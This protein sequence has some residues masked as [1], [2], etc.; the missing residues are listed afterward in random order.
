[1]NITK[2]EICLLY[3]H[4]FSRIA[5]EGGW[6]VAGQIASVVGSFVLLRVLTEYIDPAQYGQLALGLTVAGLINQ[7]VMGGVIAGISRYYPIACEKSDLYGYFQASVQ[8]MAYATLAVATLG[9]ILLAGLYWFDHV[10]WI[11]LAS[12]ALIF[13]V[14][15]AYNAAL[16][17]IQNAARQRAIVAFHSSLDSWLKI[18]LAVAAIRW[19]GSSSTAVVIGY[20]VSA[21]LV[22][23][24]QFLFLNKLVH[25]E[26]QMKNTADNW[27]KQMW[28]YSL[29]ISTWGIFTWAQ[30]ASD[31]WALQRCASTD[32]VGQYAVVFQLGYTP[33]MLATGLA[34]TLLGPVLFQKSG[35]ATNQQRIANVQSLSWRLVYLC[36]G[37]TLLAFLF[38][39]GTH[40]WIFSLLVAPVYRSVSYLLPWMLL[41]GGLFSAGQLLGLKLLCD[42]KPHAM[43]W[44]KIFTAIL[45]VALN[46]LG[47]NIAGLPGVVIAAI[48]FSSIYFLWMCIL[49]FGSIYN[50]R[51][52]K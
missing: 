8:I 39:M 44:P 14:F 42:L 3:I 40:R 36:L 23:S 13:S 33:I 28:L 9:T 38:A 34:T 50:P 6:I 52:I 49:N 21:L 45:G 47:A 35:D 19:I 24:S 15:S 48:L 25:S 11:G 29:P 26:V 1:M 46:I 32:L 27:R 17:S 10:Q 22:S 51:N 16:S 5:K 37:L 41:A 20:T 43:I 4:R 31:R 30:Q 18:V 7:V 12:A 2:C